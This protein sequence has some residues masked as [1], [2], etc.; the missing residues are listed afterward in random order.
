[1][2]EH[3]HSSFGQV[4]LNALKS[5]LEQYLSAKAVLQLRC[6]GEQVGFF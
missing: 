1:V 3:Q 5:G 6:L 2:R 4:V